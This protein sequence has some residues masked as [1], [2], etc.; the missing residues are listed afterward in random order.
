[1]SRLT[2]RLLTIFGCTPTKTNP[3]KGDFSHNQTETLPSFSPGAAWLDEQ[4]FDSDLRQPVA[5]DL[6]R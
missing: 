5:H 2:S 4:G 1:M 3:R 6:Y